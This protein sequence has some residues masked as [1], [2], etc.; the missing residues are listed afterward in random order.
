[1]QVVVF[2]AIMDGMGNS[3]NTLTFSP[4]ANAIIMVP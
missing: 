1:M 2:V 3:T 4:F